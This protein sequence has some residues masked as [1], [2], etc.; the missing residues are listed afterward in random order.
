MA[1]DVELT[2]PRAE[3]LPVANVS[4][5]VQQPGNLSYP[6]Y[7][8]YY[9]EDEVS[10]F[11]VQVRASTLRRCRQR[12]DRVAESKIPWADVTL[13]LSTLA[14]GGFLAAFL[15]DVTPGSGEEVVFFSVLPVLGV[16]FLVWHIASRHHRHQDASEIARE[17]LA[18]LPDPDKS[19]KVEGRL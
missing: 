7:P 8:V 2:Q 17:V 9:A 18:E 12:L 16:G 3:E 19:K 11:F 10:E 13:G 6:A 5:P 14:L 15:T 1:D 4:V